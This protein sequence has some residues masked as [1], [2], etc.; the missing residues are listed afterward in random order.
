MH[1]N[2]LFTLLE[3]SPFPGLISA[4]ANLNLLDLFYFV[5]L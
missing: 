2:L 5:L 1:P 4:V 3:L